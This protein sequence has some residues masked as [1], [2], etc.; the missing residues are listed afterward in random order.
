MH[1]L[2]VNADIVQNNV[3]MCKRGRTFHVVAHYIDTAIATCIEKY[4][5]QVRSCWRHPVACRC[6]LSWNSYNNL[7]ESYRKLNKWSYLIICWQY[8]FDNFDIHWQ[9]RC[10]MTCHLHHTDRHVCYPH[11]NSEVKIWVAPVIRLHI[12]SLSPVQD[13]WQSPIG[14]PHSVYSYQHVN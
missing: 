6:V 12:T 4:L 5:H 8:T 3:V 14:Y 2:I 9:N 10:T 7:Q 11:D 13:N 1:I